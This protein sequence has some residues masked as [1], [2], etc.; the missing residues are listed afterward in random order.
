MLDGIA[1]GGDMPELPRGCVVIVCPR[2]DEIR[3]L[4][5]SRDA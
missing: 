3:S 4:D 5:E 2:R 1:Q